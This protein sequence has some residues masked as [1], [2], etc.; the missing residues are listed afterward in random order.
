MT[1]SPD[2]Q[3]GVS[4]SG[5]A[6]ADHDGMAEAGPLL[7]QDRFAEGPRAAPSQHSAPDMPSQPATTSPHQ[8]QHQPLGPGSAD[9]RGSFGSQAGPF[10][11]PAH[12]VLAGGEEHKENEA[13]NF[14]RCVL[15]KGIVTLCRNVVVEQLAEV[16]PSNAKTLLHM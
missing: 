6:A 15:H 7:Q 11:A 5:T 12:D 1:S 9:P 4:Q 8:V 10:E 2:S 14:A 13:N 3:G 16:R